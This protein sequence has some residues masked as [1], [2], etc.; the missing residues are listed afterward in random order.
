MN[1]PHYADNVRHGEAWKRFT[2]EC[3]RCKVAVPGQMSEELWPWFLAGWIE[4]TKQ[5]ASFGK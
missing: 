2:A 3:R 1:E 4:K 5:R